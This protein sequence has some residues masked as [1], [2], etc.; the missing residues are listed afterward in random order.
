MEWT[1]GGR[2]ISQDFA[3]PARLAHA[4]DPGGGVIAAHCVTCAVFDPRDF[5][6]RFVEMTGRHENLFGDTAILAGAIRWRALARLEREADWLKRRIVHGSDYPFPPA[7]LPF[8][9]C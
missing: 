2:G 4:P 6:P 9:R 5:Y 7:R 3:D 1:G 8:V